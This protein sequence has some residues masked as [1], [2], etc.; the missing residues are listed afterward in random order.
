MDAQNLIKE[1]EFLQGELVSIRRELHRHPEVG[2]D[3]P[4]T[5]EFVK[6]KLIK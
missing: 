4:F 2:F 3:L 6:N 1:A 5:K